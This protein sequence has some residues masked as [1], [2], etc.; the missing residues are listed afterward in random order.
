MTGRSQ[1]F[2]IDVVDV[3]KTYRSGPVPLRALD[4]VSLTVR[5]SEIVALS[6]PSGSGK[7]TLLDI[8]LGWQDSDSGSIDVRAQERSGGIG[9][10]T[11]DLSLF[12]ELTA[13][14]NVSLAEH[15]ASS[16]LA[17]EL[18]ALLEV[19]ELGDRM[20]WELSLGQQQ[21]VAVVRA[22]VSN[23]SAIV[24]DEPTSHQDAERAA[25]V[26][27]A[28]R[29]A[30]DGGAAI[31]LT[32]HDPRIVEMCDREIRIV[33]GQIMA[34][35]VA[36]GQLTDGEVARQSGSPPSPLDW[37]DNLITQGT[38]RISA[39][40]VRF[41]VALLLTVAGVIALVALA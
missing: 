22:L 30:A 10:I 26:M 19:D 20:I 24:A 17:E 5:A 15:L 18:M 35:H 23:P 1:E 40:M 29:R 6:G 12:E 28:L 4:G 32:S 7:S 31:L 37:Q 38:V 16:A 8:V 27:G 25:L 39:S 9:I 11:Q 41:L 33:D 14:E 3:V 13:R 36:D 2:G 34:G 21:R